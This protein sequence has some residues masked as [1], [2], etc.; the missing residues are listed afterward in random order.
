MSRTYRRNK[1]SYLEKEH[2]GCRYRYWLGDDFTV[3]EVEPEKEIDEEKYLVKI[4]VFRDGRRKKYVHEK[5]GFRFCFLLNEFELKIYE[6]D[7][8]NFLDENGRYGVPKGFRKELNI[9]FR[10]V[11]KKEIEKWMK[12][13]EENDAYM[14][15]PRK[16]M[17]A[18]WI[19]F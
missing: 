8:F 9:R 16:F 17:N 12:S 15:Q 19:Y 2:G 3:K 13:P 18:A 7:V 10:A 1:K 4:L 14:P 5:S 11:S 6:K